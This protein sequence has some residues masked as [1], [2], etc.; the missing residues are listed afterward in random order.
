M[1]RLPKAVLR[2]VATEAAGG[3]CLLVA[4]MVAL[5]WANSPWGSSYDTFWSTDA[6]VGVGRWS[7]ALDLRHWVNDG[8]MALFFLVVGVEVKRELVT[9]ELRDRRAAAVPMVAALGG[10][11]VPAAI[12][13]ALTA[14]SGGSAGWGIPMATDIAFALGVLAVLGRRVPASLKLLLL[15][16]AIVD[17]IGAVLVIALAYTS[18][19]DPAALAVALALVVTIAAARMARVP[20]LPIYGALAVATWVAVYAS[21]VHATIAGVVIGLLVPTRPLAPAAVAREWAA[22]LDEDPS[23]EEVAALSRVARAAASPAE[24]IEQRL[25]PWTG[26]FVVPLFALANAGIP[27]TRSAFDAPGAGR[28]ATAV[29][30]ALVGGKVVGITAAAWVVVRTGL[31]RLPDGVSWPQLVGAAAV[32]GIGFT[33]SLFVTELAFGTDPALADAARLG[34]LGASVCAALLGAA[35]LVLAARTRPEASPTPLDEV[36]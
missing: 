30:V 33:V 32:A 18:D 12:Y 24:R 15:T 31:G 28:V 2:F 10:M 21:G 25:H 3:I 22:D 35:V 19:L 17:D 26:F 8:L 16:L 20:W 4:A 6:T 11:V 1:R 36:R 7:L 34:V 23:A 29:A 14:G 13:L 9:G 5:A 27:I